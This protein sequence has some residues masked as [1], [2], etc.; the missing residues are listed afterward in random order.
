MK[1][2]LIDARPLCTPSPGGVTRVTKQLLT[3][4]FAIDH[5]NDYTLGTTGWERASLPWVEDKR[6]HHLHRHIPNKVVSGLATF[7]GYSFEYWMHPINADLLFLP[8]SGFV[9]TPQIP[10]VLFVHD[11]TFLTEPHWYSIRGRLWHQAVRAISLMKR[12]AHLV[13]I[14]EYV[15]RE[16]MRQLKIP[17]ERISILPYLPKSSGIPIG[18][19]SSLQE[20][21][22]L[23]CLGSGDRR[24]N[25]KAV[26]DAWK[27]LQ[28][29]PTFHDLGLVLLGDPNATNIPGLFFFQRPTDDLL[30]S[31]YKHA[32]VFVYPSWSE[33]YG[34]P[35]HEAAQFG[36][37]CIASS[38]SALEETAPDGTL[39]IPPEKPH[40]L[41]EALRLQLIAPQ[42][43]IKKSPTNPHAAGKEL[44]RIFDTL[45]V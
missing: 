6:H 35:L 2:I 18:L 26:I 22:Y 16:L 24:K 38:G 20:K 12:A 40:L 30:A 33:G 37:P 39:F 8:N 29:E 5:Q 32:A 21:K 44:L 43:T 10:Y 1:R 27:Q 28:T 41:K 15:K 31:L 45:L 42:A 14:S 3:E 7:F 25:T 4:L 11:L 19:P 13:T 23:L 34:L 36:T 9:G 17:R